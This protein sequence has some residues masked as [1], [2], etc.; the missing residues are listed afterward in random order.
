MRSGFFSGL[1]VGLGRLL[2]VGV[3]I[4]CVADQLADA[5]GPHGQFKESAL[6]LGVEAVELDQ[7]IFGLQP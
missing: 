7:G 2:I 6:V 5:E 1:G 4:G 3:G